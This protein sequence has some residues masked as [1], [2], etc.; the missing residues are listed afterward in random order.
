MIFYIYAFKL[1][2]VSINLF[3]CN[4]IKIN[5]K[6]L[7]NTDSNSVLIMVYSL[8]PAASCSTCNANQQLIYS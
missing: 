2:L 3:N 4:Q 7:Y 8:F 1:I 5:E 6:L